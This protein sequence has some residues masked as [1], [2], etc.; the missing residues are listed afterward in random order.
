VGTVAV[1]R[2]EPGALDAVTLD[3]YGTLLELDDHVARLRDALS[4]AGAKTAALE[5]ERAFEA[6]LAYYAEHKCEARDEIS[7]SALR[8]AC[9]RVFTG[10]LGVDLDFAEPFTDA[11]RFR[12]ITGVPDALAELRSRGLALAVVSNWDCALPEHLERAGLRVDAIVTCAEAGVAKPAAEIFRL[13]LERLAATPER[14]LHVGDRPEDEA[15]AAAAGLHFAPAPLAAV[16][17]AWT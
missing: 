9:A 8:R 1:G 15:G 11:I 16:V 7:L 6:E 14:T 5:V 10:A 4:R 2:V 13:A 17:A 3:A 12:A